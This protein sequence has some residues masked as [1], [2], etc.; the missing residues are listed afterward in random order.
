MGDEYYECGK[1]W[2]PLIEEAQEILNE[3]NKEHPKDIPLEFMQVKEK[4]GKLC[5]YISEYVPEVLEKIHKIESKSLQTCEKCGT[6]YSVST[7]ISNGYITTLCNSCR[8]KYKKT[9][10][11]QKPNFFHRE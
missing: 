8:K 10:D 5:M 2:Y 3:W 4:F 6:T 9:K 1:G 7:E 11:G